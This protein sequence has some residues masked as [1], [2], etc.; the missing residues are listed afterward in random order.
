[1][2]TCAYACP[3]THAH[4]PAKLLQLL[5]L[6][7]LPFWP[8]LL[9][10][11]ALCLGA[12]NCGSAWEKR[13]QNAICGLFWMMKL[14]NCKNSWYCA[15]GNSISPSPGQ[16]GHTVRIRVAFEKLTNTK[17]MCLCAQHNFELH[18]AST[19]CKLARQCSLVSCFLATKPVEIWAFF[20]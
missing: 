2:R 1:M 17:A 19:I 5:P 9:G 8:S 14:S 7:L 16:I 11:V 20:I 12:S 13:T 3:F 4:K 10:L 6:L 18:L 15:V